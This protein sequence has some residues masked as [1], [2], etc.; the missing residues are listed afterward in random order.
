[1]ST[2]ETLL[3]ALK[4][5]DMIRTGFVIRNLDD[6]GM[7]DN[8]TK[9][10]CYR[11]CWA[12]GSPERGTHELLKRRDCHAP[13]WRTLCRTCG[14]V[15]AVPGSTLAPL[16]YRDRDTCACVQLTHSIER[17]PVGKHRPVQLPLEM[18]ADRRTFDQLVL[19]HVLVFPNR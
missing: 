16:A 6:P 8:E 19:V 2:T 5:L 3:A 14:A 17:G 11:I 13:E 10:H 4:A 7:T 18:A 12:A 1:V 15:S 9:Y